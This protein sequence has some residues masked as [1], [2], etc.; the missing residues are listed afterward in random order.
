MARTATGSGPPRTDAIE[1]FFAELASKGR[2][3][4]LQ[5]TVGT[6]RFDLSDDGSVERWYVAVDKGELRV[7]HRNARAD[8]VLRGDKALFEL[9]MTGQTNAMAAILRGALVLEGDYRL[10][11][12]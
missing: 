4:L 6:V 8:T 7:S 10:A 5:Q 11:A 9:I 1:A 2:E 12:R 3:P